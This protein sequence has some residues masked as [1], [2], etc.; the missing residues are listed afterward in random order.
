MHKTFTFLGLCLYTC[1]LCAQA[2]NHVPGELL[3]QLQ[4][5]SDATLLMQNK[6][7]KKAQAAHSCI[8][9]FVPVAS[10]LNIWKIKFD[11]NCID[12]TQLLNL[13][14][15]DPDV[16]FAQFNH[17]VELRGTAPND[18][19]FPQQWQWYNQGQ[20]GGNR[21]LDIGLQ[22]AWDSTTGGVTT[23]GDS[24]VVAI[25]DTGTDTDHEDLRPNLWRN[26][27]EIPDNRIDDDGN[28]YIDDYRGWN[29]WRF[30]DDVSDD[31]N[32]SGHGTGIA[33][34]I[35]AKGDNKIGISG[36]N[37]NVKLMTIGWG[38]GSTSEEIVLRG[39]NYIYTQRKLYNETEGKKGAYVVAI[40]ASWGVPRLRSAD[41]PIWCPFFDSLGNQGILTINAAGKELEN[42]E[43][44]GD[45]PSGCPSDYL[46]V[47]TNI[48]GRG[49]LRQG[50]GPN[51]ADLA[52]PAQGILS[53]RLREDFREFSGTSF[54]APQVAGAIAL[55][56]SSPCVQLADLARQSPAEA[57]LLARRL[58]LD[59]VEPIADLQGKVVTGGY[60]RVDKSL[61]LLSAYCYAAAQQ[62][63]Q[64]L[65]H[66]NP[67]HEQL[68]VPI[69]STQA[70]E[71]ATLEVFNLQ[72][73]R[74]YSQAINIPANFPGLL[75]IDA[76]SWPQGMYI[77]RLRWAGKEMVAQKVLKI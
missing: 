34:I 4:P 19:L 59:G 57:A 48:D 42:T 38:L 74:M 52:A 5:N 13:L 47:V 17:Y 63:P 26:T 8:Q 68:L 37:W 54:A 22:Q 72:G 77:L 56:Y 41:Y 14:R 27:Q 44:F 73:Q 62:S 71:N 76:N 6:L 25:I 29:V 58:I 67:F 16:A 12:E 49:K 3:F 32:G 69:R 21:G 15:Q 45:M 2:P 75:E 10:A 51:T 55:L 30:N 24:I 65:A 31:L 20:N 18:P 50:Y 35:G 7:E 43:E 70:I 1:F 66:P 23:R 61:R 46:M 64:L 11:P 40:N 33:G 36:V 28:G 9:A 60:L 53:T 39:F